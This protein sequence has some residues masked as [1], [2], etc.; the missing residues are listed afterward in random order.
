MAEE[1]KTTLMFLVLAIV[2]AIFAT[3]TGWHKGLEAADQ[4]QGLAHRRGLV[5]SKPSFDRG[6]MPA[7]DC[8]MWGVIEDHCPQ[9]ETIECD[10][11]VAR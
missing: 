9:T 4:C 8:I 1:L 7:A 2:V 6:L 5:W 3:A 10:G 11:E